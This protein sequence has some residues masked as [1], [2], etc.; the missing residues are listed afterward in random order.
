MFEFTE[1]I[2]GGK[3]VSYGRMSRY[4]FA[5]QNDMELKLFSREDIE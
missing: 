5:N 4:D 3:I 2:K 1:N